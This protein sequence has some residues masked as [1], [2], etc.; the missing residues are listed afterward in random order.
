LKGSALSFARTLRQ[1][2]PAPPARKRGENE[3]E[4]KKRGKT[5]EFHTH[6]NAGH[7]FFA[8]DRPAIGRRLR[9]TD[10]TGS[11]NGSANISAHPQPSS[12]RMGKFMDFGKSAADNL[13]GYF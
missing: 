13:F 1:G 5:Y 9:S 7:G 11:F 8:A 2:G 3:E 12:L 4:L 10:G 6:D